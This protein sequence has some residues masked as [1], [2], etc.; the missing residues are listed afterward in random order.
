VE[1]EE[2]AATRVDPLLRFA[3]ALTGDRGL[4]EDIVQDVALRLYVRRDDLPAIADLDS[5]AR[6]MVVNGYLSWGRKWFRV[7]PS[8]SPPVHAESDPADA[9]LDRQLMLARLRRLPR[10]QRT[11]LVL[12]YYQGLSDAEIAAELRCSVGTVRSHASRALAVLRIAAQLSSATAK[13]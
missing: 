2:F 1:F 5:Y 8:A 3:R 9:V 10:R 11:V 4:A 7:L 12:R 13:E 6:R